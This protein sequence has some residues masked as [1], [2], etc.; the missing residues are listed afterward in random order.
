MTCSGSKI[1]PLQFGSRGYTWTFQ[2]APVSVPILGAD[3]L[4]YH[5]LHVDIA[6]ERL[7]EPSSCESLPT[8]SDTSDFTPC[9]NLLH[10]FSGVVF[11]LFTDH[12]P[13]THALFRTFS[14]GL[15]INRDISVSSSANSQGRLSICLGLK[16]V[17]QTTCLALLQLN[18]P[19]PHCQ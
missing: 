16:T 15:L 11:I 12:K 18:H 13:L 7:L 8:P 6:G 2:L 10:E 17:L 5:H 14:P 4:C 19:P 1:I 9:N 3:F